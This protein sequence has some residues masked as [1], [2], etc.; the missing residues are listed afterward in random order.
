MQCPGR[1]W[2][3]GAFLGVLVMSA[4]PLAAQSPDVT[5][6]P[7]LVADIQSLP[8]LSGPDPA[9]MRINARLAELDARV[10]REATACNSDPPNSV[11]ARQVRVVFAGPG[12]LGLTTQTELFCP[13]AAHGSLFTQGFTFDLTTGLQLHWPDLFPT[14]LLAPVQPD[15]TTFGVRGSPALMALY[16]S[17]IPDLPDEC[18]LALQGNQGWFR[19]WPD[20]AERGLALLPAG[21][22]HAHQDCAD[23]VVLPIPL[24]REH[25][26]DASLIA[27]LAAS[28]P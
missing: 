7:E 19:V 21:L 2:R 16:L 10:L 11:Y 26:F 6:P 4:G 25:G 20:A 12:L 24:L 9:S 8:R 15:D 22:P 14:H 23:P 27:N 5:F 3:V 13:G 18:R 28:L 1:H 17:E